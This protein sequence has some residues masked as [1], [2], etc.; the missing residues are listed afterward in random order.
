MSAAPA[1]LVELAPGSFVWSREHA[2]TGA[3]CAAI[4]ATFE[5]D[6]DKGPGAAGAAGAVREELKR[7]TDACVEGARWRAADGWLFASLADALAALRRHCPFFRGAF[8][9]QGYAVQRT[10]AGE[11]Y[12][13]H[14]DADHPDLARRQLV[15][16]W[17]LNDVPGP[18]GETEFLYQDLRVAPAAG[19]LVLFPPFWTHAHRGVRLQRGVKYIATTWIVFA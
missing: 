6:P 5:Q 19:R 18:G 10:A 2:L 9:D 16:I 13:W 4:I 17:Y 14:V 8:K 3:Q 1:E 11:Y 12:H 15:A 7:S